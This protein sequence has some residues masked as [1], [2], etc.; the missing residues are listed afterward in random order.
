[1][2][3]NEKY[4]APTITVLGEVTDLTKMPAK[5]GSVPDFIVAGEHPTRGGS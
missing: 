3:D 1:V 2:S 4:E 5:S